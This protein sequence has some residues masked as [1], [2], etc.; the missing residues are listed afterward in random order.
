MEGLGVRDVVARPTKGGRRALVVA[1]HACVQG[2]A[3]RQSGP[4]THAAHMCAVHSRQQRLC[5]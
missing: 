4:A 5:L 3:E 2:R 1:A